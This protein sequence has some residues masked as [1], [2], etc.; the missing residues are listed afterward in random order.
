M[1]FYSFWLPWLVGCPCFITSNCSFNLPNILHF[2]LNFKSQVYS[3]WG[4][5]RSFRT[6]GTKQEA[7]KLFEKQTWL[8]EWEKGLRDKPSLDGSF[9]LSPLQTSSTTE[10]Q[11]KMCP[12][13]VADIYLKR[14]F[15]SCGSK[16][17]NR[18]G[19]N[20]CNFWNWSPTVP[21]NPTRN[22]LNSVRILA[23]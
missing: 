7:T 2:T 15:V 3:V 1:P 11:A 4:N 12:D 17:I 23:F 9:W 19:E 22:D 13:T 6:W 20:R 5:E 8:P 16:R 18:R 14:F 21:G 10:I